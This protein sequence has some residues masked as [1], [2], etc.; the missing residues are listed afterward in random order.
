MLRI[1]RQTDY[2]VRVVLAL[3]QQAANR[4]MMTT[5]E[6]EESMQIPH[7]FLLR[8]VAQLAQKDLVETFPGRR[9]GL[10]LMRPPEEITLREIVEAIEGPVMISECIP[11]EDFC[12]FEDHCPVRRRW[13]RLQTVI[14]KELS[15]TTFA[16]L[17]KEVVE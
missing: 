11:G 17:A 6:I 14:L 5:R 10:R 2:A 9:G 13:A 15:S 3:S 7:A 16:D 8:I 1:T 4:R 12:P